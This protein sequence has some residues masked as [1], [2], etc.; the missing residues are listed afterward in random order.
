MSSSRL[1][2]DSDCLLKMSLGFIERRKDGYV[3]CGRW[4]CWDTVVMLETK[5]LA[6]WLR[7]YKRSVAFI[8][9]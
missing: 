6:A 4:V 5:T 7:S 9:K 8:E 3:K 2:Y 1:P